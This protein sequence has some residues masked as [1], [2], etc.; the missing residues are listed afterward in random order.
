MASREPEL[1]NLKIAAEE[2]W[3]FDRWRER[4]TFRDMEDRVKLPVEQGG[5]GYSISRPVLIR[6]AKD[7]RTTWATENDATRDEWRESELEDLAEQAQGIRAFL[8]PVDEAEARK[9][10]AALGITIDALLTEPRWVRLVPLRDEK[11][12]LAAWRELREVGVQRRKLLGLDAAI[13]VSVT[14][15]SATESAIAELE[16][17]LDLIDSPPEREQANE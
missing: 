3:A 17:Q 10:A 15:T 8:G 1:R 11:V 9:L 16:R 7:Y 12:R 6:R 14:T 5:L 4:V 2:R 13:E